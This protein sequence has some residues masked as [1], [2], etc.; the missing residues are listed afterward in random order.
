M[1][2]LPSGTPQ[3]LSGWQSMLNVLSPGWNAL[4]GEYGPTTPDDSYGIMGTLFLNTTEERVYK[5]TLGRQ[6]RGHGRLDPVSDQP[7]PQRGGF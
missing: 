7:V 2:W 3:A 6:S 1:P 5:K 4:A